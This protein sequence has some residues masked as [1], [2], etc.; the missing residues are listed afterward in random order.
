MAAAR[1]S[2]LDSSF[3]ALEIDG[4]H[5]HVGWRGRFT[6]A[7]SGRP[8]LARLRAGIG[9]RLRHA[10]RFRQRLA[11]PPGALG[12]PYWVDD[13]EFDLG[14]H[15]RQ[16]GDGFEALTEERFRALSDAVLSE[17]LDR[18]RPLWEGHLAPR[19]T[20]G[21]AGLVMKMHHPMV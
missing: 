15:V 1:L 9:G 7:A 3:L 17:P 6:P 21:G 19:L 12:E 16:L 5:M 18:R 8:T 13:V 10:P 20:D 4:A 2:T 11:F 14:Y